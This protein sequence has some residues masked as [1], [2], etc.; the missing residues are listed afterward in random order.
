MV[1][2]LAVLAI[3]SSLKRKSHCNE[4]NDWTLFC[5]LILKSGPSFFVFYVYY[6]LIYLKCVITQEYIQYVS[7]SYTFLSSRVHVLLSS[8]LRILEDSYW[9]HI[10][11]WR[12]ITRLKVLC[13][14]IWV[15][16]RTFNNKANRYKMRIICISLMW[17]NH[18]KRYEFLCTCVLCTIFESMWW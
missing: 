3:V 6:I 18:S 8:A 12:P 11:P 4:S 7:M 14:H 5:I 15:T 13:L 2:Y 16:M 17:T 10:W 1:T 9:L